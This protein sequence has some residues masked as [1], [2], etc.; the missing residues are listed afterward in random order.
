M[1]PEAWA[2][3]DQALARAL[4]LPVD[5]RKT[6]VRQTFANDPPVAEEVLSL[7]EAEAEAG[8]FLQRPAVVLRVS[9]PSSS[10]SEEVGGSI[11]AY[12]L[13]RL[14]GHGGSSSVYLAERA[15]RHYRTH[16]AI[17]ILRADLVEPAHHA[18][19]HLERQVLAELVHPN[20]A[21]L[22]DGGTTDDGRPYLVMEHVDGRPLERYCDDERL[23][24]DQRL[25]LMHRVCAAVQYAHRNLIVHRDLK[26]GNILVTADGVPKLLD[27]GIA[28]LLD[29]HRFGV[30]A[31]HTHTGHRPMTLGWASP[32]QVGGGSITTATDVYALGVLLFRLLTGRWPYRLDDSS[33]STFERAVLEQPARRPSDAVARGVGEAEIPVGE[34]A[35]LET[36]A[37]ARTTTPKELA[38]RLRGDLDMIV[39]KALRKAPERRYGSAQ[40]LA[41]DLDRYRTHQPVRAQPERWSYRLRKFVRRNTAAT[42]AGFVV[43]A[44]VLSFAVVS[45]Y[46]AVLL[47]HQRDI[48]ER[49]RGKAQ[50]V[51][52][53]ILDLFAEADPGRTGGQDVTVLEVLERGIEQSV[54][55]DGQPALQAVYL[56]TIGRV[57]SA[58]GKMEEAE[59]LQRQALALQRGL[60]VVGDPDVGVILLEL[61]DVLLRRGTYPAAERTL[62]QGLAILERELGPDHP[63]LAPPLNNLALVVH[64]RGD[65]DGAQRL[66]ETAL[67]IYRRTQTDIEEGPLG[68]LGNLA[69]LLHDRGD[70]PAAEARYQEVLALKRRHFGD[71]HPS[72]ASS[73]NN[74]A[75]LWTDMGDYEAAGPLFR[76][77]ITQRRTVLGDMHP[78]LYRTVSNE[79]RMLHEQG[80]FDGAEAGY[81]IALEKHRSVLGDEHPW[82]ARTLSRLAFLALDRGDLTEA[83]QRFDDALTLQ[84]RLLG[85]E[86]RRVG[87]TLLGLARLRRQQGRM[88]E[89][90]RAA[91]RAAA[92]FRAKL[93]SDHWQVRYAEALVAVHDPSASTDAEAALLRAREILARLNPRGPAAREV[94]ALLQS[95]EVGQEPTGSATTSG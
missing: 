81:R 57:Y 84:R 77:T 37:R 69:I 11:G 27:F 45:W 32:E 51:S 47:E 68:L 88:A 23:T 61:G 41:D 87:E 36:I 71:S 72:T 93:L 90:H 26:P 75:V 9:D 59:R 89:A 67:A 31:Q 19:F 79:A 7:L 22:Y 85:D 58:L 28:K 43:A 38:R 3:V 83:D 46:Q 76:E 86:H 12:R 48:A 30:Q 21:R 6:F 64:S 33:A 55:L 65:Y 92:I 44:S 17:K 14:I 15:D 50:Q 49:E 35:D 20:I 2:K 82:I 91:E 42:V 56:R 74:L 1:S 78:S 73:M 29:A 80:D 54:E 53:F 39:A 62:R 25:A 16:V 5:E 10:A 52:E 4:A 24:I 8:P 60:G 34:S 13:R 70:Y 18:R 94:A 40:A 63:D 66:Y 95:Y